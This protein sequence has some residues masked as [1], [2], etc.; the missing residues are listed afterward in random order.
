VI[1][2]SRKELFVVGDTGTGPSS[3]EIPVHRM[4]GLSLRNGKVML[5]RVVDPPGQ[6]VLYLLQRVSL[7]LDDG[8]VIFGFGGNAGDCG[9]YH[10]WVESVPEVG[11]GTID[12]FEVAKGP[13]QA[14]GAVWMG[15]GA[16]VIASNGRV[17]VADGN[18]KAITSTSAYD[19]SDALLELTPK[20]QLLD[21]FAPP[22]WYSDNKAD[23]DLGSGQ[24]ELLPNGLILQVGKTHLGYVLNPAHLGHIT[25]HPHQFTI[26][27]RGGNQIDQAHGGD[28]LVGSMVVVPCSFG[29]NAVRVQKT[30]PYG[31][32]I[33]DQHLAHGPPAYAGGLVWSVT[34]SP[35]SSTLYALNPNTGSVELK[36]SIG[37]EQNHFAT[38]AIGDN[39][40]VVTTT[41]QVDVFAPS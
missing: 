25:A 22:T 21:Y 33:W 26:C 31:H 27:S 7:A 2:L 39:C 37:P 24:P 23:L 12:R 8:R 18:G 34:W 15:G 32:L 41:T 13:G 38:P 10:G 35:V 29:L 11:T 17:Y 20:M 14:S 28:A 5:D 4:Y 9:D 40:V 30:S 16:P 36:A 19:D 1:D 6:N 3:D